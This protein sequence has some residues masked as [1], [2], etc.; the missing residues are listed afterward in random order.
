MQRL[1]ETHDTPARWLWVH[2]GT[3]GSDW[4]V[5]VLPSQRSARA[6]SLPAWLVEDPT[7]MQLAFEPQDTPASALPATPGGVGVGCTVHAAANA[8]GALANTTRTAPELER[9]QAFVAFLGSSEVGHASTV[10]A[11]LL[12]RRPEDR[13]GGPERSV[14]TIRCRELVGDPP[15]GHQEYRPGDRLRSQP[16]D[17]HET[18]PGREHAPPEQVKEATWLDRHSKA[19]AGEDVQPIEDLAEIPP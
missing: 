14:A 8:A 2:P 6:C 18:Q 10:A 7:A 16:S 15:I 5:H 11:A 12:D 17:Q 3:P 9:S 13:V 19:P 1:A 4:I